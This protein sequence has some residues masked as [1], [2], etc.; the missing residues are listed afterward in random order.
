MAIRYV[1]TN[2]V[3]RDWR[4][5]VDFYVEVFGCEP[6]PPERDLRGDWLDKSTGLTDAHLRGMHLRLPG[7]GPDGPTLEI[8]TYEDLAPQ[9]EP[10]ANRL[11]YGHLA[12]RVDD[13]PT[14]FERLLAAGGERL[15][16]P[17]ATDVPGVGRLEV[18]YARDPEGNVIELQSWS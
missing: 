4:R 8:F 6:V 15:G 18:V 9:S 14:T 12:F 16:E 13:V 17:V 7:H 10:T 1:H 3:A 2:L 5:L 11:G